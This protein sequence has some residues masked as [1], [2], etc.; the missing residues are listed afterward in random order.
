MTDPVFFCV[1]EP[2]LIRV[3]P[4]SWHDNNFGFES[5]SIDWSLWGLLQVIVYPLTVLP[6]KKGH[7]IYIGPFGEVTTAA[8][9][10]AAEAL[11]YSQLRMMGVKGV[12]RA[13]P[14][15]AYDLVVDVHGMMLRIQVKATIEPKMAPDRKFPSY[16]WHIRRSAKDGQSYAD[17][18][19]ENICLKKLRSYDESE[20]DIIAL[21]AL[22]SSEV[23]Y[24]LVS[25]LVTNVKLQPSSNR[26][27]YPLD[28]F[29][30]RYN[31]YMDQHGFIEVIQQIKAAKQNH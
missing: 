30:G 24:R 20:V 26:E 9:G 6:G 12:M 22:D 17:S 4:I 19:D 1:D 2:F 10:D 29:R 18:D 15:G 11:V 25:D 8:I 13:D 3:E 14:G 31:G 27:K 21:V 23:A 7:P 28:D 5:Y 16:N